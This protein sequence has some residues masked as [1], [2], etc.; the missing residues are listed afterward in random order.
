MR[1]SCIQI[2]FMLE[3]RIFL[4]ALRS[5]IEH[6]APTLA[7]YQKLMDNATEATASCGEFIGTLAILAYLFGFQGFPP[8]WRSQ[9][10]ARIQASG[11]LGSQQDF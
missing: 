1:E 8:S 9:L 3:V 10:A 5:E 4:Q 2:L 6:L 11:Q 7:V